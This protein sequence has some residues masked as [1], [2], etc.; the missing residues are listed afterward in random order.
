MH[1]ND[2]GMP[3]GFPMPDWAPAEL[4]PRTPMQGHYCRLEPLDVAR[5]AEDLF[6]AYRADTDNRLWTY[7][8]SGPFD[9]IESFSRWAEASSQSKDPLVH[10]VIDRA[11]EIALGVASYMRIDPG[12][13]VIEVGAIKYAPVLQRT[14]AGT[15]AMYLLMKRAFDE[16]GYRRYEWKCNN[17]NEAS[18]RAATRYGF[19][20]EG[21]FRQAAIVKG[22]NR[23]TAWFAIIDTEWPAIK[24][25]FE[26]WL[27]PSNFNG[28][29][30]QKKGLRSFM[31]T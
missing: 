16:L 4:P 1:R 20:F 13:G 14:V 9:D 6:H 29:G 3:I 15:E 26:A 28:G 7:V 30:L 19:A 17:L 2:L 27:S 8:S 24:A 5:H 18:K 21:V 12:N 22:R 25:A 31:P 23:D 10:A 11:T